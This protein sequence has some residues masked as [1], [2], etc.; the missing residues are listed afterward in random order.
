M[1]GIWKHILNLLLFVFAL[2]VGFYTVPAFT[3]GLALIEALP[4]FEVPH[5]TETFQL[6]FFGGSLWI[7]GACG[8]LGLRFF[9]VAT[10]KRFLYLFAPIIGPFLWACLML[11]Y[12]KFMI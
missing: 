3:I 9:F 12:F 5:L 8:F 7:Y 4:V 10:K 6:W 11:L 2:V 1:T